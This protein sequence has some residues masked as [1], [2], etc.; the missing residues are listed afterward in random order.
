M[1][2]SLVCVLAIRKASPEGRSRPCQTHDMTQTCRGARACHAGVIVACDAMRIPGSGSGLRESH[3][4]NCRTERAQQ[5]DYP[6]N[7]C[8]GDYNDHYVALQPSRPAG[9]A[10]SDRVDHFLVRTAAAQA[11]IWSRVLQVTLK[12]G[13]RGLA[14]GRNAHCVC[15]KWRGDGCGVTRGL[16][17]PP[18]VMRLPTK[19]GKWTSKPATSVRDYPVPRPPHTPARSY[20]STRPPPA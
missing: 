20:S 4:A 2:F 5:Y 17:S 8:F 1:S 15:R 16:E 10:D 11:L 9:E 7:Q 6:D 19:S 18:Y 14:S 13:N 12:Q 3:Y